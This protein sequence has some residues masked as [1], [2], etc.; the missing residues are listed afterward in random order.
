MSTTVNQMPSPEVQ[1][2]VLARVTHVLDSIDDFWSQTE[3]SA[4]AEEIIAGNRLAR[5]TSCSLDEMILLFRHYRLFTIRHIDDL[6]IVHSRLP[7]GPFKAFM[8][9]VLYEEFGLETAEGFANNHVAL[10]DSFMVSLGAPEEFCGNPDLEL[11]ANVAMLDEIT[12]KVKTESLYAAVGLRGMGAECLCQVYLTA[13]FALVE[14]NPNFIERKEHLDLR[15]E[16]LHNGPLEAEHRTQMRD[17]VAELVL[18]DPDRLAQLK[19]GYELART[20]FID[21]FDNIYNHIDDPNANKGLKTRERSN[22]AGNGRPL[23]IDLNG[24]ID[25]NNHRQF[26]AE[27]KAKIEGAQAIVGDCTNLTY[28]SSAGLRSLLIAAKAIWAK[29]GTFVLCSLSGSVMQVMKT[30]GFDQ[31]IPIYKD[32]SDALSA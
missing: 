25:G 21:F 32:R 6:A 20:T 22:G 28:I 12:H 11:P 8:S 26:D 19:Y 10:L 31:I 23:V 18:N 17:W 4:T 1:A 14:K 29:K 27:M 9:K 3:A 16:Q 13:I 5:L 24:R 2:Q 7:F 30:A 15:F